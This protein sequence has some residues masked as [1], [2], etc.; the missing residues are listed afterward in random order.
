METT[1]PKVFI[2]FSEELG[3]VDEFFWRR[4]G[5]MCLLVIEIGNVELCS[6]IIYYSMELVT[7]WYYS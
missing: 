6:E 4:E 1:D 5:W 2:E 7:L 3:F